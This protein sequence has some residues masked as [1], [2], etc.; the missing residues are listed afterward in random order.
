MEDNKKTVRILF[1]CLGNICRSP[2]A[3]GVC[4][5]LVDQ[6]SMKN[7]VIASCGIGD[8]HIG[9]S[10]DKRMQETARARGLA[11][12][13]IAQQFKLDFFDDFDYI[14]GA[15]QEVMRVLHHYANSPEHKAKLFLM[16]HF[17]SLYQEQEVPD[18]YY[19]PEAAFDLVLDMLED[20]CLGLLRHIQE[21]EN[22]FSI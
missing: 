15:D 4:K 18:P 16:T 5:H 21:R 12:N 8:W 2:A 22:E 19:Q 10:P 20:S 14:L 7:I 17:S 1:V 6:K 11:L 9:K 3:E 13:S